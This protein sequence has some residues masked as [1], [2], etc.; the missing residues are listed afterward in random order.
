MSGTWSFCRYP[1]LCQDKVTFTRGLFLRIIELCGKSVNISRVS[2]CRTSMH[3]R[4]YNMVSIEP[5]IYS[6][7][8]LFSCR[9]Y[10]KYELHQLLFYAVFH[11]E[12]KPKMRVQTGKIFERYFDIACRHLGCLSVFQDIFSPHIWWFDKALIVVTLLTYIW[13]IVMSI[14]AMLASISLV[15]C[16]HINQR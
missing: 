7:L 14:C 6:L 15:S 1:S 11:Y 10:E 4:Q 8:V 3:V 12:V 9:F 13:S 2:N 16:F 5:R